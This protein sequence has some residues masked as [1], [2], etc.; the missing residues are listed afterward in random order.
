MP[1]SEWTQVQAYVEHSGLTA[2]QA[3]D[4]CKER[5]KLE[6]EREVDRHQAQICPEATACAPSLAMPLCMLFFIA[7]AVARGEY[8]IPR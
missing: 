2:D 1:E 6:A 7:I 3:I 5:A 4:A 8:G